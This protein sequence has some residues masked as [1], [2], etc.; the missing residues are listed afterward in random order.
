MTMKD[1]NQLLIRHRKLSIPPDSMNVSGR[2]GNRIIWRRSRSRITTE[3]KLGAFLV[4]ENNEEINPANKTRSQ[5]HDH[6][7]GA[8]HSFH[9]QR[10]EIQ[11]HKAA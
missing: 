7:G 9:D 10:I 4:E 11:R 3:A 6:Q 8:S 2:G 5:D 1:L